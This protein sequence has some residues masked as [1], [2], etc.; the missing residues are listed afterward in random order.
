MRFQVFFLQ[1][2]TKSWRRGF[3]LDSTG[4]YLRGMEAS[5]SGCSTV[6]SKCPLWGCPRIGSC[7]VLGVRKRQLSLWPVEA[8]ASTLKNTFSFRCFQKA[9]AVARAKQSGSWHYRTPKIS[10]YA[11]LSDSLTVPIFRPHFFQFRNISSCAS[12]WL[13]LISL[14]PRRSGRPWRFLDKKKTE[15]IRQD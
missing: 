12:W 8:I 5:Y 10:R 14:L 7:V 4:G 9:P 6:D 11:S 13:T 3:C 15:T 2:G 1:G